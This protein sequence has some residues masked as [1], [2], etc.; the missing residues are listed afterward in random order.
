MKKFLRAI[1][2]WLIML[3]GV[4]AVQQALLGLATKLAKKTDTTIDDDLVA[5]FGRWFAEQAAKKAEAEAEAAAAG[6]K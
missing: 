6:D 1:L 2:E 4:E 3:L 5:A